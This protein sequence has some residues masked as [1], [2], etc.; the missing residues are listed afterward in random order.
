MDQAQNDD[1]LIAKMFKQAL[2]HLRTLF[3]KHDPKMID[4]EKKSE[5][6]TSVLDTRNTQLQN[7]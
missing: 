2:K 7:I 6:F 3:Q 1:Q 5:L 4:M